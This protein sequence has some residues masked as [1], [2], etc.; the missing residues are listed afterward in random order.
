MVDPTQLDQRLLL[1]YL[2][3]L[4]ELT[5]GQ[6]HFGI[7]QEIKFFRPFFIIVFE[8]LIGLT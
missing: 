1:Q 3:Y 5:I 6:I 8:N 7:R 2:G 4:F